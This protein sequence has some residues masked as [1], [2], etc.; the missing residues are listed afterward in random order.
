MKKS[1]NI[2]RLAWFNFFSSFRLYGVVAVIYFAQITGSYALGV[3]IY[4]IVN[5]ARAAFEV[6]TGIL[7]DKVGRSISLRLGALASLLSVACYALG[8]NYAIL[9]VGAVLE[10][11]CWAFF[12]GNNNALL[13]ESLSEHGDQDRY[14]EALGRA[15]SA[16]E[17]AGFI[18]SILGGLIAFVSFGA[19]LWLS[20]I[21]QIIALILSLGFR[22]P[23]IPR[24]AAQSLL[25]HLKEALTHYRSNWRLRTL[26][27]AEIIGI[28][29]G[30]AAWQLQAAFY[31]T[32]LPV[33]AV[34][35]MISLNFL[36]STISFRLSGRL[37]DRFK[38]LNLL[39]FG[40][41]YS[42]PLI[43]LALIHPTVF[44][45][46][47]MASASMMYGPSVV[48]HNTLLQREFTDAQRATMASIN[49]LAGG[50]FFALCAIVLGTL[51]DHLGLPTTLL[52]SQIGMLPLIVLY[53]RVYHHRNT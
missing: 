44:S 4:S 5:I 30:E 13:Y 41:V 50:I 23:S 12:S 46:L 27:L 34:G 1:P 45:P 26:S 18:A 22:D 16:L 52:I 47:L 25:L 8:Q 40:E 9:A 10:G 31:N 43:F 19:L 14:H 29:M 33:W 15:H 11:L 17:L 3:S 21:P 28:G 2:K 48:A 49:S 51:A 32:L 6:P 20:L 24:E 38:A 39:I 7:S 42:R 53:L 37:I 36:T 35:I